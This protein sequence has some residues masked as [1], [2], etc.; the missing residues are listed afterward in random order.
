MN[1]LIVVDEW[2]DALTTRRRGGREKRRGGT[3]RR[4]GVGG[5]KVG[6]LIVEQ[7]FILS[8]L[9]WLY[10]IIVAQR[11]IAIR[12]AI[13]AAERFIL[14]TGIFDAAVVGRIDRL[15][16]I[17]IVIVVIITMTTIVVI[18]RVIIMIVLVVVMIVM[19]IVVVVLRVVM[20]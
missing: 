18:V 13:I 12:V 2:S 17:T 1:Y 9:T 16:I 20:M 5:Q 19:M 14:S 8:I 6:H 3:V 15:M 11:L 4:A 7:E 10:E